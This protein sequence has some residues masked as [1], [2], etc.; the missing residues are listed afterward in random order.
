MLGEETIPADEAAHIAELAA[1]LRSIQEERDRR[2]KPVPRNVHSK[3]HGCVRAELT[4]EPGLPAE[5]RQGLFRE[6]RT[7]PALL[8]FSNSKVTDDRLPDAH[9]LGIKLL[10]VAG[11]KLLPEKRA[12]ATHDFVLIDHPVFFVRDVADFIPLAHDFRRLMCGGPLAKGLVVAKAAV[13]PDY[14]FRLMRQTLAKRPDD[15]LAARYWS[16]SPYRFGVGAVK[17]SLR[18][19]PEAPAPPA[20]PGADK[21]RLA[22]AARLRDREAGFDFLVQLQTNAVTMP[23]ED[24]TVVW[25]EAESPWRKVASLRIPKQRFDSPEQMAFAEGL[26]FTPWHAIEEHRPLGGINRAR[27]AIYE[28]MSARRREL[29]GVA[30]REPTMREVETLWPLS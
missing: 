28:A 18:P 7:Y 4:V 30:T 21:L 26:S 11:E 19:R 8:R 10:D 1:I 23:V 24:P 6:P 5:L 2:K 13:S 15:P 12:A 22:M 27:R 17:L 16:A 14:R 3:Q 9:G 29:N 20:A 25:D